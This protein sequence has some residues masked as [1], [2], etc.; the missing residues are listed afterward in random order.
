[1]ACSF[2][3]GGALCTLWSAALPSYEAHSCLTVSSSRFISLQ[4]TARTTK[5]YFTLVPN[6]TLLTVY[7]AFIKGIECRLGLRLR[8]TPGDPGEL[9]SM[10]MGWVRDWRQRDEPLQ[11]GV[12]GR[13]ARERKRV[14]EERA[15]SVVLV[16][17][18]QQAGIHISQSESTPWSL[19]NDKFLWRCGGETL[20]G[21]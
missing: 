12:S 7:S 6:G 5:C 3:L 16:Q 17:Q 20:H 18:Q 10:Q 21:L 15:A 19:C 8:L 13:R 4:S 1:M 11:S 14:G 9:P 2:G